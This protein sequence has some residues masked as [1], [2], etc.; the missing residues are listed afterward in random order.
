MTLSFRGW[1]VGLSLLI[2][3]ITLALSGSAIYLVR[4]QQLKELTMVQVR[5][6][7]Y[8]LATRT[9]NLLANVEQSLETMLHGAALLPAKDFAR[10]LTTSFDSRLE[11]R[12]MYFLDAQGKTFAVWQPGNKNPFRAD[13]LGVDFS[14]AQ[15]Y[16]ALKKADATVWSDKF[17]S[18]I[19]GDTSI[20]VGAHYMGISAIAELD[21]PTLL[22][23]VEL[24]AGS[25]TKLWVLD[26]VG[27]VLVDTTA[28]HSAGL[29]NLRNKSF[30]SQAFAG[31]T[32]PAEVELNQERYHPGVSLSHK[33][34]WLFVAGV[35]AGLANPLMKSTLKDIL[36]LTGSFFLFSLLLSPLV[37]NLLVHQLDRLKILAKNIAEGQKTEQAEVSGVVEFSDLAATLLHMAAKIR[38]REHSLGQLNQELEHRVADRTSQLEASNQELRLSL[39]QNV[40]MQDLLVQTENLAALGRL[41][42]GVSHE[43][44]TPIGN[45]VMALSTLKEEK[46]VLEGKLTTGLRKSELDRFFEQIDEGLSIAERN[47]QRAAD[48]VSSFKQVA[49]DQ[50]SAAR[51]R[52][53]LLEMV[54]DVLLTLQPMLK[55]SPHRLSADIE[56]EISLESYPGVLGQILT[57]LITNALLHAWDTQEAGEIRVSAQ[58]VGED[59]LRLSVSDNGRGIPEPLK[60]KIFEPFYTTAMG[61]GGPDWGLISPLTVPV[62][63]WG[64][65]YSVKILTGEAPSFIWISPYRHPICKLRQRG[66]HSCKNSSVRAA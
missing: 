36:L 57:N 24:A 41:V 19:V 30:I 16:H 11:I 50:T 22:K 43:L 38:Q 64:A 61:Q 59:R 60:K 47:V 3:L 33:L 34:G 62:M 10:L 37:L 27:E 42:A 5:E 13:L 26:R 20:G 46:A 51:R 28:N 32:M 25:K 45:A 44:N 35:P 48:L 9:E 17:V 21:L 23:T 54:D 58:R 14:N 53:D 39:E 8:N 31:K 40:A 29:L 6:T 66:Y 56:R 65:R 49:V 1:L 4:E 15:L 63:S 12:A 18:T 52:F 55:R 7:A 2:T